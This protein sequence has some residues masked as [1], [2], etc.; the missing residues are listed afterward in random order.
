[1]RR[2]N[3]ET[4]RRAMATVVQ[5]GT[6]AKAAHAENPDATRR[7][8][9][10]LQTVKASVQEVGVKGA[11]KHPGFRQGAREVAAATFELAKPFIK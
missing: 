7:L 8:V 9:G 1:M 3:P 11:L 5:V 4:T 10:G 6:A 2:L